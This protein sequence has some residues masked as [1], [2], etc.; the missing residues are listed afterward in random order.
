MKLDRNINPDGRGKY[1][2]LKL[3][4]QEKPV[5]LKATTAAATL[6]D[7]GL[8]HFG[9]EGP[10]EQFFVLKYKDKFTAPALYA[11]AAAAFSEAFTLEE[12]GDAKQAVEL[13]EFAHE[14]RREAEQAKQLGN[15][16]PS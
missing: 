6:K 8:L 15:S 12:Q 4:R 9:N 3:R 7:A 2:L 16:I 11:Y 13:R 1:A 14:I 5:S 10:G